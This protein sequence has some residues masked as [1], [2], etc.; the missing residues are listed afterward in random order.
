MRA[1]RADRHCKRA[2][3]DRTFIE[4]DAKAAA[5]ER[6]AVERAAANE[7]PA[8]TARAATLPQMQLD[9][10]SAAKAGA[11]ELGRAQTGLSGS[12]ACDYGA[13]WVQNNDMKKALSRAEFTACL[14]HVAI[15]RYVMTKELPDIADAMH[16]HARREPARCSRA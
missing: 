13:S 3:L 14:V 10:P 11:K 5:L 9:S 2:D 12:G 6:S 15:K 4:V 7:R 1:S 16:R 8:A